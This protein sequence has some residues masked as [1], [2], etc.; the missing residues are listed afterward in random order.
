MKELDTNIKQEAP[1]LFGIKKVDILKVPETYFEELPQKLIQI[2]KKHNSKTILLNKWIAYSS[3]I[4]ALFIV[5]FF[6]LQQINHRKNI[7]AFNKSFNTLTVISFEEELVSTDNLSLDI[8][9]NDEE[10][11]D[12]IIAELEKPTKNLTFYRED[13]EDFFESE[14]KYIY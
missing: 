8:D 2:T 4:A 5:G 10:E 12:F 3:T 11:L 6:S 1:V 14:M 13:F 9:F 7:E